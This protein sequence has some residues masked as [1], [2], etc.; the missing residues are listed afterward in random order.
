MPMLYLL[1]ID[2]DGGFVIH[3][4]VVVMGPGRSVCILGG[5]Q[6]CSF[7]E[8]YTQT[9]FLAKILTSKFRSRI[10]GGQSL[11]HYWGG[12]DEA[13]GGGATDADAAV[14]PADGGDRG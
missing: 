10:D 4:V 3:G 14:D 1:R 9:L 5:Y 2:D 8:R 13:G 7:L 11:A 12:D 6:S